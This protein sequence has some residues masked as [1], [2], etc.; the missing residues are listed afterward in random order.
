LSYRVFIA[1]PKIST[2]AIRLLIE[3]DCIFQIG[4]LNVPQNK[5]KKILENFNPDA[6]IVRNWKI[7][8]EEINNVQNLKVISKH[9]V[10]WD[11]ID[12]DAATKRGI[13]VL[14]TPNANY[15]SVAEHTLALMFSLIRR[16]T[17]QDKYIRHGLFNKKDYDGE[18]LFGKTLGLIGYGRVG[19]RLSELIVPFKMKILVYDPICSVKTSSRNITKVN[20]LENV[21]SQ[22]DIIS[23]HCPL[24]K[25]TKH[26]I[27]KQTISHM[28]MKKSAYLVNTAR[29]EI[30]NETDLFQALKKKQIGGAALD[31]F[32][33]EPPNKNSP[34]FKLEDVVLTTHIGGISDNS[35]KNM[36]IGAVKNVLAVLKGEAI[37]TNVLLNKPIFKK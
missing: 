37:S 25:E 5:I 15:E 36:G 24:T 23:L 10:G 20:N 14:F 26:L 35:L 34:L 17:V 19:R 27:N 7:S 21:L 2:E 33:V 8:E 11:N 31:V 13:P 22:A 1:G 29:G 30:V 18:E 4:G 9:G 16:I 12:I 6:I 32:E 28:H 3:E